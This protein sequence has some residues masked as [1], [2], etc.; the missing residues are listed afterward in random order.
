MKNIYLRKLTSLVC[1]ND[2][3]IVWPMVKYYFHY[4]VLEMLNNLILSKFDKDFGFKTLEEA[5]AF[6]KE[7]DVER[8]RWVDFCASMATDWD[9][10][11]CSDKFSEDDYIQVEHMLPMMQRLYIS[12]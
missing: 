1:Y 9:K 6:I 2:R 10:T 7:N 4:T 12:L 5:H 8:E 11:L 3:A